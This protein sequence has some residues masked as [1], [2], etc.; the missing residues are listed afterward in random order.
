MEQLSYIYDAAHN[1]NYRTNNALIQT[2]AVNSDNELSTISRNSTGALTVEGTTGAAATNVTV[3]G[4]AAVLYADN[5]FAE[6]GFTPVNGNNT[7]HAIA[8]DSLGRSSTN[9]ITVNLPSSATYTYDLNGNLTSDGTRSFT[10]DDENQLIQVS[11]AG[12]WQ[13]QFVY[14]GRLRRRISK[15]FAWQNSAWVQTNETHYIYDGSVVLQERDINNLPQVGYARGRDLSGSLQ[16]AGGIGGLLS[17]SQLSTVN[18]QHY[19]YLADGNGNITAMVNAQQTIVAKYLYDSYGNTLSQSGPLAGANP[20]RFSSK[21]Y[22][23]NS[24]LVY[25][26]Y[27]FYDPNLQRWLN[28]DPLMEKGGRNLF[29]FVS[30][31][32]TDFSDSN[33]R[34]AGIWIA[35]AKTASELALR[36]CQN[37]SDPNSCANC[38]AAAGVAGIAALQAGLVEDMIET[39]ACGPFAPGCALATAA[40]YLADTAMFASDIAEC[41]E[42]CHQKPKPCPD[43]PMPPP[44]LASGPPPPKV[45]LGR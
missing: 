14:D 39:A 40:V 38:C 26:L 31:R 12:A 42:K 5:T 3:N 25:Y 1:L 43:T 33:G 32:P 37:I 24:G 18:P 11:V 29:T 21:E 28:R 30:N 34:V 44:S 35:I 20:Y 2:F 7:Y 4:S 13:S 45:T 9:A 22:H 17:F 41:T 10:Y 36:G 23:Q 19:Y 16:G 27:R 6:A 8:K 15:E